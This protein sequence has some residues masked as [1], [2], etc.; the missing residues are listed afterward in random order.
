M[1]LDKPQSISPQRASP[2]GKRDRLVD[3][4]K[5]PRENERGPRIWRDDYGRRNRRG[6][7]PPLEETEFKTEYRRE[8]SPDGRWERITRR[9]HTWKAFILGVIVY[10]L[11]FGSGLLCNYLASWIYQKFPPP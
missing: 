1:S 10:L 8:I 9:L 3:A 11:G 5:R 6:D 2:K 7:F 4:E